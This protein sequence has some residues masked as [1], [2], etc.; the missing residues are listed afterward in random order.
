M[1]TLSHHR[2][3]DEARSLLDLYV[4]PI[5]RLWAEYRVAE[6]A[7]DWQ[8]ALTT[9]EKFEGTGDANALRESRDKR[10]WIYKDNTREYDKAIEMYQLLADPPRTLWSIAEC[11][12]AASRNREAHN[13]L[14]EIAGSFPDEAPRAVLTQAEYHREDGEHKLAVSLYRQILMRFKDSSQ[15][16]TAHQRLEDYG[17]ETGGGVIDPLD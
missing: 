4:N 16:S 3:P 7:S 11:H 12:R 6:A 2:L 9:L 17:V 5:K 14:A 8:S 10:A 13:T 15:S 1:G